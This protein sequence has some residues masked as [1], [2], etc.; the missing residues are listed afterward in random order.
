MN[1]RLNRTKEK[2]QIPRERAGAPDRRGDRPLGREKNRAFDPGRRGPSPPGKGLPGG[3]ELP[4]DEVP[5]LWQRVPEYGARTP[6]GPP[7]HRRQG[8]L[9]DSINRRMRI[10][11][12]YTLEEIHYYGD[13]GLCFTIMSDMNPCPLADPQADAGD[14]AGR[15]HDLHAQPGP[16]RRK[17]H[18]GTCRRPRT[19]E[20]EAGPHQPWP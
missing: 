19:P 17:R 3:P 9:H 10:G 11:K 20:D 16:N 6:R 1:R 13:K 18:C 4:A 8:L 14:G 15:R 2:R 12:A 7:A 5:A